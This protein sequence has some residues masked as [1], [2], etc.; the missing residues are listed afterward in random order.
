[1]CCETRRPR[2]QRRWTSLTCMDS[3]FQLFL[4]LPRAGHPWRE[5]LVMGL[6]KDTLRPRSDAGR[7][8]R[9]GV[10]EDA[11]WP[12]VI[13]RGFDSGGL[14]LGERPAYVSDAGQRMGERR[15]LPRVN[16]SVG[17]AARREAASLLGT[18]DQRMSKVRPSCQRQPRRR[19]EEAGRSDRPVCNRQAQFDRPSEDEAQ[20]AVR[21]SCPAEE[22]IHS[23]HQTSVQRVKRSTSTARPVSSDRSDQLRFARLVS[24]G[25]RTNVK[26]QRAERVSSGRRA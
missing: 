6:T 9:S 4:L 20:R 24:S 2:R 8:R 16:T 7:G 23:D 21:P 17:E 1:M 15:S 13:R 26:L 10:R 18:A 3:S 12:R 14:L 5:S 19:H 11:V 25:R 22:A